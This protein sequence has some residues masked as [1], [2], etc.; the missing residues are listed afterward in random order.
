MKKMFCGHMKHR[1]FIMAFAMIAITLNAKEVWQVVTDFSELKSGDEIVLVGN[2]N[3]KLQ[4]Y[5]M[6]TS[7]TTYTQGAVYVAPKEGIIDEL[8]D[9]VQIIKIETRMNAGVVNYAFN[10]G[11]GYLYSASTTIRN[12]L[13]VQELLDANVWWTITWNKEVVR[14]ESVE[15]TT[16]RNVL[17]ITVG[18]GG[19]LNFTS[20]MA[21][22]Y[23]NRIY[24]KET[25][26]DPVLPALETPGGLKTTDV[27][28]SEFTASW[29]SVEHASAYQLNLYRGLHETFAENS[30]ADHGGCANSYEGGNDGAWEVDE[31]Y[32]SCAELYTDVFGWS[33]SGDVFAA[34]RS[35]LLGSSMRG[36]SIQTPK[37]RIGNPESVVMTIR[38]GGYGASDEDCMLQIESSGCTLSVDHIAVTPSMWKEYEVTLSEITGEI[39]L[40][41][42]ASGGTNRVFIDMVNVLQ[43]VSSTLTET[44]SITMK[45]L[46]GETCY[47]YQIVAVGDQV[48][49]ESSSPSAYKSVMM[50]DCSIIQNVI[51]ADYYR[52]D[53]ASATFYGD[54]PYRVNMED[55]QTVTY[56]TLDGKIHQLTHNFTTSSTLE[57]TQGQGDYKR[58]YSITPAWRFRTA[59]LSNPQERPAD[60]YVYHVWNNHYAGKET[61][62]GLLATAELYD[63]SL[64]EAD[65]NDLCLQYDLVVIPYSTDEAALLFQEQLA[66]VAADK[67]RVLNF[68]RNRLGLWMEDAVFEGTEPVRIIRRDAEYERGKNVLD[69]TRNP[70][71]RSVMPTGTTTDLGVD[72]VYGYTSIPSSC[73]VR[74][75]QG[76]SSRAAIVE[77]YHESGVVK[78]LYYAIDFSPFEYTE[79][80]ISGLPRRVPSSVKSLTDGGLL[81]ASFAYLETETYYQ[82]SEGIVTT[83]DTPS[84]ATDGICLNQESIVNPTGILLRLYDVYGRELTSFS[85][86]LDLRLLPHGVYFVKGRDVMI[87]FVR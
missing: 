20:A 65:A 32:A 77:D 33:L 79:A 84:H 18:S 42:S 48:N 24:K 16:N 51:I 22:T 10:V 26:A 8:P 70:I 55:D 9:D 23:E 15:N 17:T 59:Y 31:S 40:T 35:V 36:G 3:G 83:L 27:C 53:T 14:I 78:S 71:F 25:I 86:H 85:S 46:D 44:A 68:Q 28:K 49:Y 50:Y 1:L 61:K 2:E 7:R 76:E 41:M 80:G 58:K 74:A 13:K 75:F 45:D 37:I 73:V 43:D 6:T 72:C 67:I 82:A 56:E 87:K 39:I 5:A 62:T 29:T 21:S 52:L 57:I 47:A 11:N 63:I 19:E 54:I 30:S 12:S 81:E 64:P 34:N 66:K 38:A 4:Y 60:D 69:D